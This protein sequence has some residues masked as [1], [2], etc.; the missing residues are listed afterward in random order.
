MFNSTLIAVVLVGVLFLVW[1]AYGYFAVRTIEEPSYTVRDVHDGYEVRMYAPHIVAE[2]HVS[3]T[4]TE[5]LTQGF[6][7][8]ADYIFG[9]NTA[10]SAIAMTAPVGEQATTSQAIAMTV[11][12]GES[13]SNGDRVISFVMPAKYTLDTIPLPNNKQVTLRLVPAHPVAALRYSGS[14]SAAT[15]AAKKELLLSY[16]NRDKVA[17]I[18]VPQSAFYN[19][20]WTP[21]FMRRN[22]VLVDIK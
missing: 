21:P 2:A 10:R 9:N 5:A 8:I 22:E 6:R 4:Y 18:G 20:P 14:P 12:V 11:P 15:V 13:E 7:Q 3:G 19:P 16:L 17:V 1:V